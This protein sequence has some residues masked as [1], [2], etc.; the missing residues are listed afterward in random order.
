MATERW[1]QV[2]VHQK[3]VN[4]VHPKTNCKTVA[5]PREEKHNR[6]IKYQQSRVG[7]CVQNKP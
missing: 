7:K 1:L 3:E 2:I 5:L 6:L 4:D